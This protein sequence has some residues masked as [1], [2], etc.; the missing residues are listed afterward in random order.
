[1]RLGG[2]MRL[3]GETRRSRRLLQVWVNTQKYGRRGPLVSLRASLAAA[4][5][6][7]PAQT[8]GFLDTRF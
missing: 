1:M 3:E 7:N 4:L 6:R 5:E 8:H 2:A